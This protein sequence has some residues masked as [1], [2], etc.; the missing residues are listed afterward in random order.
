[1]SFNFD[2][3]GIAQIALR[4]GLVSESQVRECLAELDD[5]KAPGSNMVKLMERNL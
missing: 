5:K 2:A 1:M 4:L 3:S